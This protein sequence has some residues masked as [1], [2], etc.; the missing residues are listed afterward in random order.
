MIDPRQNDPQEMARRF[1]EDE[2]VWRRYQKKRL[3]LF[4]LGR[5]LALSREEL[6]RLAWTEAEAEIRPTRCI[7]IEVP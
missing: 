5:R 2:A 1:N 7:G 6:E 3:R 4:L